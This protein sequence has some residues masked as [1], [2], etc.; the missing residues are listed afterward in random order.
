VVA[1]EIAHQWWGNQVAGARVEGAGM[2]SETLAMYSSMMVMER[3]YG[4]EMV[5]K[6]YDFNMDMYLRGHSGGGGRDEKPLLHAGDQNHV[7]YNKG[8]VAMYV[9]KERIGEERVN[10]ALRAFLGKWRNAGPP[11]ATSLDLYRELQAV[12]PDSVKPVLS[13]L[14]ETITFWDVSVNTAT[15]ERVGPG[16]YRVSIEI[17]AKKLR[18]DPVNKPQTSI[19]KNGDT[20]IVYRPRKEIE[21]PMD[22][23][24]E[25]GIYETPHGEPAQLKYL[26]RHRIRSGRQTITVMM[27]E[28]PW[29]LGVDPR[30]WLIQRNQELKVVE[31][32]PIRVRGAR[33]DTNVWRAEYKRP[34]HVVKVEFEGL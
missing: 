4:R 12:T 31:L 24:V 15:A 32:T 30:N 2:L 23:M 18:T 7:Y 27:N 19:G 11:Y 20:A 10:A 21:A 28:Q 33:A 25:I 8:A 16:Q 5:K 3:T 1:H 22:E 6:F 34:K 14:F 9:L 26:E 29:R 17:D 13:D